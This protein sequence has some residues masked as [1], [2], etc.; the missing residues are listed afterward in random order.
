MF[1]GRFQLGDFVTLVVWCRDSAGTP[2]VPTAHP[3]AKIYDAA[4]SLVQTHDLP[5]V[6]SADTTGRFRFELPLGTQYAVGYYDVKIDY[7]I[8][9]VVYS[10]LMSF[11]VLAGGHTDGS[12]IAAELYN[13][14]NSPWL[15]AETDRGTLLAHRNPRA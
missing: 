5:L 4:G 8:S 14:P 3:Q 9:S 2:A 15:V 7:T 12:L 11:Q 13:S 1:I 10:E 6:D